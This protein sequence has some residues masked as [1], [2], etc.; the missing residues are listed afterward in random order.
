MTWRM[1]PQEFEAVIALAG[2]ER[3]EYA[4]KKIADW[5]N[6]WGLHD[7]NG[8]ALAEDDEGT[9]LLP[10][11]PHP[12]LASACATGPWAGKVAQAIEA[13]EWLE[14]W[15]PGLTGDGRGVA[16]FPTP[17]DTGVRVAPERL[18]ADLGGELEKY[19]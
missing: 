3:Y 17:D 1:G 15:T 16:V 4:V 14:A 11:W 9:E 8:W 2:P 12:D 19:E 13:S 18:A 6:V 7:E 5:Q 10:V